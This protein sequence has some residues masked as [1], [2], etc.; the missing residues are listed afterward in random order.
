MHSDSNSEDFAMKYRIE[1]SMEFDVDAEK[2]HR[3][4]ELDNENFISSHA[5]GKTVIASSEGDSLMTLLR[6]VD[7]FISCLQVAERTL[8]RASPP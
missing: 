8:K 2:L 4:V 5:K 1:L 3:A 7:D 6:T